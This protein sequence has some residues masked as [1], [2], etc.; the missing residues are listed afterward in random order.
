LRTRPSAYRT[1]TR[2]GLRLTQSRRRDETGPPRSPSGTRLTRSPRAAMPISP[3]QA[4]TSAV[5]ESM[6]PA[7]R[8]PAR[9]DGRPAA[10]R[11]GP[12]ARQPGSPTAPR[13]RSPV[14]ARAEFAD[15]V[16]RMARRWAWP[17]RPRSS[18]RAGAWSH[19]TWG[20][21]AAR[22]WISGGRAAAPAGG[23]A[24][25]AVGHVPAVTPPRARS[26]SA[27]ASPSA[28]LEVWLPRDSC[29]HGGSD[30]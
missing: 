9:R 6:R 4:T 14:R 28:T 21:T 3:Y 27:L 24:V 22:R 20:P 7:G 5:T 25:R 10:R 16:D 26:A 1:T 8:G 23:G 17:R 11:R 30:R 19:R 12:A 15:G 13:P 2:P 18:P 29:P